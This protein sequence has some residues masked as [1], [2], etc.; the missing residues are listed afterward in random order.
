MSKKLRPRDVK[1]N[2]E[3]RSTKLPRLRILLSR[4]LRRDSERKR[5]RRKR[6]KPKLRSRKP[7]VKRESRMRL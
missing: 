3:T 4:K 2:G 6:K 5:R 7:L 1:R